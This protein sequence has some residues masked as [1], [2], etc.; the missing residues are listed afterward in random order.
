MGAKYR[1]KKEFVIWDEKLT[2]KMRDMSDDDKEKWTKIRE[3]KKAGVAECQ[4][5]VDDRKE[6]DAD[7]KAKHEE[8]KKLWATYH[9]CLE[10]KN[11]VMTEECGEV[12]GKIAAAEEWLHKYKCAKKETDDEV[13]ECLKRPE[14]KPKKPVSPPRTPTVNKKKPSYKK[15][16]KYVPTKKKPSFGK[17]DPKRK[18]AGQKPSAAASDKSKEGKTPGKI[19]V[20]GPIEVSAAEKKD[21]SKRKPQKKTPPKKWVPRPKKPVKQRTPPGVSKEMQSRISA[22]EMAKREA[23]LKE[24]REKLQAEKE[25]RQKEFYDKLPSDMQAEF[26]QILELREQL[27]DPDATPEE[28]QAAKKEFV[29]QETKKILKESGGR[30][31]KK[32]R[33]KLSLAATMDKEPTPEQLNDMGPTFQ[34]AISQAINLPAERISIDRV[35]TEAL[36]VR[37]RRRLVQTVKIGVDYSINYGEKDDVETVANATAAISSSDFGDEVV[38][39][40]NSSPVA[41]DTGMVADGAETTEASNEFSKGEDPLLG[42]VSEITGGSESTSLLL[43]IILALLFAILLGTAFAYHKKLWCFR[44]DVVPA[45]KYDVRTEDEGTASGTENAVE[46]TVEIQMQEDVAV[47]VS[48]SQNKKSDRKSNRSKTTMIQDDPVAVVPKQA[49]KTGVV[50][51]RSSFKF[52]MEEWLEEELCFR[53]SGEAILET[54][55]SEMQKGSA[56]YYSEV[57][58]ELLMFKMLR[59]DLNGWSAKD[60][61]D[62]AK[63]AFLATKK[64]KGVYPTFITAEVSEEEEVQSLPPPRKRSSNKYEQE[65]ASSTVSST[66]MIGASSALT[67]G[68]SSSRSSKSSTNGTSMYDEDR[69]NTTTTNTAE[70]APSK[71]K[72][73]KTKKKKETGVMKI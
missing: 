10:M 21:N 8:L 30:K 72:K 15:P 13:E 62:M 28:K 26:L 20:S 34:G 29:Q 58:D 42:S 16:T 3:E 11:R 73:R 69:T 5:K 47:V 68:Y 25:K 65:S 56:A 59:N 64:K 57:S 67:S 70:V 43:I 63:A 52:R 19:D 51:F 41:A 49:R 54:L 66:T 40:V 2:E 45:S 38:K 39:Q 12:K 9:R 1:C 53:K 6:P 60:I 36:A 22:E 55:Y 46:E 50:A 27:A 71:K 17:T 23:K 24:M 31:P 33:A 61:R 7:E 44:K 32:T 18:G 48:P 37:G 14:M 35:F 4:E